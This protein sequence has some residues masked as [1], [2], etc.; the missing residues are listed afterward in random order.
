MSNRSALQT[1]TAPPWLF[2]L[3]VFLSAALVFTVEPMTARLV[4]PVLGGSAAVWNTS[5]VFFQAGPFGRIPLRPCPAARVVT[6]SPI[7]G[8]LRP[9]R[10]G[11]GAEPAARPVAVAAG[12]GRDRAGAVAHRDADA[13]GRR[14]VFR[15]LRNRAPA[16]GVA[17]ADGVG[18]GRRRP[19]EPLRR[20][21][22]RK[23][24]G[25]V[26]VSD[27]DRA[28]PRPPRSERRVERRLPPLRRVRLRSWSRPVAP[29]PDASPWSGAR[30]GA[31]GLDRAAALGRPG[32]HPLQPAAWRDRFR[33]QRPRLRSFSM[34]RAPGALSADLCSRVPESASALA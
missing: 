3:V 11:G 23:P 12:A 32:R 30:N 13:F 24:P 5:L 34:G 28:R 31:V 15:P 33:H 14:S 25:I 2:A 10:R 4:L 7:G 20:E 18:R 22:S 27:R 17:R 21:Q 16:P 1:R 8:A 9:A 26:G 6:A 19:E 29:W